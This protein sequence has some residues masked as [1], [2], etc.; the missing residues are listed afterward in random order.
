MSLFVPMEPTQH[1]RSVDGAYGRAYGALK[2]QLAQGGA[3]FRTAPHARAAN[4]GPPPPVSLPWGHPLLRT[5]LSRQEGSWQGLQPFPAAGIY[6]GAACRDVGDGV[7]FL[8]GVWNDPRVSFPLA[9]VD[10]LQSIT[11]GVGIYLWGCGFFSGVGC[12]QRLLHF[13][14]QTFIRDVLNHPCVSP[15][16]P[17]ALTS[18]SWHGLLPVGKRPLM[19]ASFFPLAPNFTLT[20]W[21]VI[22]AAAIWIRQG[23]WRQGNGVS[24]EF[25]FP[26]FNLTG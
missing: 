2:Q 25:S 22:C 18:S 24:W 26:T 7:S 15:T 5:S 13:Q 14:R 6:S 21:M 19:V 11:R 23:C 3:G 10:L 12:W 4:K 20:G 16:A 9:A 1:P 17:A 8:A